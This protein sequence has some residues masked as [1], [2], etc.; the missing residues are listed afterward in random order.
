[1]I[2]LYI[3]VTI[4]FIAVLIQVL[5]LN[6]IT[7]DLFTAQAELNKLVKNELVTLRKTHDSLIQTTLEFE[8][9]IKQLEKH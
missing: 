4:L 9:R 6:P 5:I 8:D 7:G 2:L 3:L 1:M